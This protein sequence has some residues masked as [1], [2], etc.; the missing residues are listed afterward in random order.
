MKT[1]R[2]EGTDLF[3]VDNS[4]KEWKVLQYLKKWADISSSF[5]IA[6]GYFETGI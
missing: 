3:I 1:K 5:D 6:T 4:D 2:K